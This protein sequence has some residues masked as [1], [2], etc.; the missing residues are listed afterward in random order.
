[1]RIAYP[2][3][4]EDLIENAKICGKRVICGG[5]S[6]FFSFKMQPLGEDDVAKVIKFR[7]DGEKKIYCVKASPEAVMIVDWKESKVA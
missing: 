5:V 4:A 6:Y 2:K 1:M 7:Y 3:K